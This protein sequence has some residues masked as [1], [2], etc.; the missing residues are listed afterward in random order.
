MSGIG[1][2]PSMDKVGGGF[3]KHERA[4]RSRKSDI[5]AY[6]EASESTKLFYEKFGFEQVETVHTDIDGNK[7]SFP[8]LM[9][10]PPF[11]AETAKVPIGS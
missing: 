11:T 7:S 9:W 8:T 6:L 3:W 1:Y 5:P 10:W 4:N 2:V